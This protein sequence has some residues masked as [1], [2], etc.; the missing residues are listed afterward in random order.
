MRKSVGVTINPIYRYTYDVYIGVFVELDVYADVRA[1]T[2]RVISYNIIQILLLNTYDI[3][4][5]LDMTSTAPMCYIV[6]C[7]R[8]AFGELATVY[9][10]TYEVRARV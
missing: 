9:I 2:V 1:R 3:A 6:V 5:D 4:R 7:E 10:T 8:D